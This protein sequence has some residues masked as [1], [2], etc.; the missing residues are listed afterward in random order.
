MAKKII[1]DWVFS[2]LKVLISV[3]ALGY[4]IWKIREEGSMLSESLFPVTFEKGG[5]LLLSLLMV[6]PN[7]GIEALKWVY[8]IRKYYPEMT[9]KKAVEGI[10]AGNAV[11][12]FT[13]NRIGEYAGRMYYLPKGKRTEALTITLTDRIC[14]MLIT[15]WMGVIAA[16]YMIL[17]TEKE[18]NRIFTLN[19]NLQ[20]SGIILLIAGCLIVNFIVIYPHRLLHFLDNRFQ[21]RWISSIKET[22]SVV[23]PRD[24]WVVFGLS[25][26]RYLIFTVQYFLLLPVFGYTGSF[27]LAVVLIWIIFLIKSVIPSISL[28]ELG[29]RESVAIA[30]MSAFGIAAITAAGSTF[31]LYIFNIAI[32]AVA[33]IRYIHKIK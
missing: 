12:I 31:L 3:I 23:S 10:L 24:M 27:L 26:L 5:Y 14:Q 28:A 2:S 7:Q 29:I 33:G 17:Y 1:P 11:G 15:L 19:K 9:F 21:F 6:I 18:W 20:Y 25:A 4:V 13:P 22:F 32:P 30:V 16:G 8:M